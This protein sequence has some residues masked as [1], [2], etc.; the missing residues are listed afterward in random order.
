MDDEIKKA[1]QLLSYGTSMPD[2]PH[3]YDDMEKAIKLAISA[4]ER[5]AKEPC[6]FCEIVDFGNYH[7]EVK[8]NAAFISTAGGSYRYPK[9]E[10][11]KFCPECGRKLTE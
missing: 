7:A 6:T 4:L 1:I 3:T 5:Q 10:Q 11:F 9:D 8:R 2:I